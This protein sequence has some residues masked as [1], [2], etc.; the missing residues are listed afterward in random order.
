MLILSPNKIGKRWNFFILILNFEKL[1]LTGF[2]SVM[3]SSISAF[4]E[5]KERMGRRLN[6]DWLGDKTFNRTFLS[7]VKTLREETRKRGAHVS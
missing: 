5:A 6:T 7:G 4:H 3:I 2:P 1:F